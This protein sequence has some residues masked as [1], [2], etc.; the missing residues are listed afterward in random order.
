MPETNIQDFQLR[1][2]PNETMKRLRQCGEW[3]EAEK[4]LRKVKQAY[5]R[6][7]KKAGGVLN[8]QRRLELSKAGWDA[9]HERWPPPPGT[10]PLESLLG[11]I[12]TTKIAGK[13]VP[14]DLPTVSAAAE[15]RFNS[16]GETDDL[17]GEVLWV[18]NNLGNANVDPMDAPSRGAWSLLAHARSDRKAF[19]RVHVRQA[20]ADQ[21]RRKTDVGEN[22][23]KPSKAE[24][25][26]IAEIDAMIQE[27]VE[28]SQSVDCPKCGYA[29]TGP[30]QHAVSG[31][32]GQHRTATESQPTGLGA[33]IQ[34]AVAESQN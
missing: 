12:E 3:R 18:Y 15:R 17:T 8:T 19:Y 32:N 25:L 22:D 26:A 30:E 24:K 27:A 21:N 9:V 6:G 28:Q 14:K 13:A 10:K 1:E 4:V 7:F 2:H 20:S 16:I 11:Y 5:H 29:I 23:Y 34:K 33:I 31:S